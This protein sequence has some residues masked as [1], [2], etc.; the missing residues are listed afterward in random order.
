M[1]PVALSCHLKFS[2]AGF[3]LDAQVGG[4]TE[5]VHLLPAAMDGEEVRIK[6]F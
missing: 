2:S 6:L 5:V 3:S 4:S 1:L